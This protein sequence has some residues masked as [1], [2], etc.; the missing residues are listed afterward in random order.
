MPT[1]EINGFTMNYEDQ[2][3]GEVLIF[4]HGWLSTLHIWDGVIPHLAGR[5]R[6]IAVDTRG[7]GGSERVRAGHDLQQYADDV[8]S[9]AAALGIER[10]TFIGHSMGGVV[11]TYAAL[12]A[13]PAV[14]RIVLVSAAPSADLID[15]GLVAALVGAGEAIASGDRAVTT[16]FLRSVWAR[17]DPALLSGMVDLALTNSPEFTRESIQSVAQAHLNDRLADITAP[18]LAVTGAADPFLP[19]VLATTE[20]MPNATLHVFTGVC[21]NPP[22]EVPELLAT[23]IDDF[24]QHGVVTAEMVAAAAGTS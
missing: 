13:P 8:L 16:G 19:A 17:P 3:Q 6:C 5:Y 10:F 22:A 11:A 12:K 15:A 21:H 23:A 9:L 1:Q 4:Q 2:G 18:T 24:L 7:C 20:R 14:E